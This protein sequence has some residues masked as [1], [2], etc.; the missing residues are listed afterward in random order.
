MNNNVIQFRK[1]TPPKAPRPGLR[2][3]LTVLGIVAVFVVVW[4]YFNFAGRP[5]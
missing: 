4:L 1:P 5:V 3:L 2:K